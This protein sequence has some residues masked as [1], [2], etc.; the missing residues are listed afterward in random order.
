MCR[1]GQVQALVPVAWEDRV[2]K[3]DLKSHDTDVTA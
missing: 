2:D 3:V 1:S